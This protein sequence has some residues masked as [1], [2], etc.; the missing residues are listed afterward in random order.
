[1]R[2]LPWPSTVLGVTRIFLYGRQCSGMVKSPMELSGFCLQLNSWLHLSGLCGHVDLGALVRRWVG[3]KA[4]HCRTSPPQYLAS[5]G[6]SQRYPGEP[7]S[8]FCG[9]DSRFTAAVS[10]NSSF[11]SSTLEKARVKASS[12]LRRRQRSGVDGAAPDNPTPTPTPA[13]SP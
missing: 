7:L 2:L 3:G 12:S 5:E 13:S 6:I 11:F 8:A 4:C 9:A 1:M 10:P